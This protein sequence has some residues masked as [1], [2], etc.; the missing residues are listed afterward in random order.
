MLQPELQIG[1][2]LGKRIFR[3]VGNCA[4]GTEADFAI[5]RQPLPERLPSQGLCPFTARE[6]SQQR[7]RI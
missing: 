7:S 4:D 2:C 5:K 1:R 3:P 6:V